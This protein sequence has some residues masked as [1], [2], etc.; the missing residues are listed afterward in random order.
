MCILAHILPYLHLCPRAAYTFLGFNT[1]SVHLIQNVFNV[2]NYFDSKVNPITTL[3]H[4]RNVVQRYGYIFHQMPRNCVYF[5]HTH[6]FIALTDS[7]THTCSIRF[8]HW[9]I[10]NCNV[11]DKRFTSTNNNNNNGKKNQRFSHYFPHHIVSPALDFLYIGF[12]TH[13]YLV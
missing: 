2:V 1:S 12:C 7:H 8:T 6:T 3:N 10:L 13:L 5:E 9:N 11:Q 4:L